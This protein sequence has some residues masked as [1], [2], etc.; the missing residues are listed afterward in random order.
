MTR[1]IDHALPLTFAPIVTA[2]LCISAWLLNML[3]AGK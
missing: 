2:I 3:T 1:I